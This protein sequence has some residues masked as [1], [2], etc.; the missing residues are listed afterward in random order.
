MRPLSAAARSAL[1]DSLAAFAPLAAAAE[2]D[3]LPLLSRRQRRPLVVF[4][5]PLG[6]DHLAAQ[7]FPN[8]YRRTGFE[9]VSDGAP[10]LAVLFSFEGE[11][12]AEIHTGRIGTD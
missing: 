2:D 1:G 4:F 11:E 10:G 6:T 5:S 9:A 12:V 7:L 8:P 3:A